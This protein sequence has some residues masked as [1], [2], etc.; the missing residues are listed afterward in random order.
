MVSSINFKSTPTLQNG[1]IESTSA[2]MAT[3]QYNLKKQE[4]DGFIKSSFKTVGSIKKA[5]NTVKQT[6]G[7]TFNAITAGLTAGGAVMGLDWIIQR[8]AGKGVQGQS[9]L[10]TPFKTAWGIVSG[11]GKKFAK[12]FSKNTSVGKILSYP[13]VGFP[14]DIYN[15]VKNAKGGSKVGK[16]IAVAV[17]LGAAVISACKSYIK[18]N[19]LNA[20]VDHGFKMGHNN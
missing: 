5:Y 20:E 16:T 17:G 2:Q 8:V 12:A 13:F 14:K 10:T 9:I 7:G 15:Y 3:Q 11:A 19:R 18:L 6:I 1:K 4:N